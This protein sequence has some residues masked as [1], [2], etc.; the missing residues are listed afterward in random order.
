MSNKR[1]KL[2]KKNNEYDLARLSEDWWLQLV[3]NITLEQTCI[4]PIVS[5]VTLGG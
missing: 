4:F 2:D 5:L 3:A 1:I